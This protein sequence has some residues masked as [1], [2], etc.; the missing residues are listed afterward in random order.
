MRKKMIDL[1]KSPLR[2]HSNNL[3]TDP[4]WGRVKIF[5]SL[6]SRRIPVIKKTRMNATISV[7]FSPEYIYFFLAIGTYVGEVDAG[8]LAVR[9]ALVHL[10]LYSAPV[11]H[12]VG[13]VLVELGVGRAAGGMQDLEEGAHRLLRA[14]FTS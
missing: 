8:E 7:E 14:V 9:L 5:E 4:N 1:T 2:V 10:L 12:R 11:L 6:Q 3:R 13:S